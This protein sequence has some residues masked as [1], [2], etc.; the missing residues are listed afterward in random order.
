MRL[1]E[2]IAGDRLP[3]LH[4]SVG[5]GIVRCQHERSREDPALPHWY[6][7]HGPYAEVEYGAETAV[8]CHPLNTVFAAE[9]EAVSSP[10]CRLDDG[11]AERPL[12][13]CGT[14]RYIAAVDIG[15]VEHATRRIDHQ[16]VDSNV[17]VE[18]SRHLHSST[19][20]NA[21]KRYLRTTPNM[22]PPSTQSVCAF[23]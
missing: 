15:V 13:T 8:A 20:T 16:S 3:Q 12:M 6:V 7:E 10:L 22:C 14:P 19:R 23:T 11:P 9:R 5:K 18:A 21:R 17:I 1:A 2:G 4:V